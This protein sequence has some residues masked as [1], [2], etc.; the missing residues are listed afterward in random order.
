MGDVP[1]VTLETDVYN[2]ELGHAAKHN[3][4]NAQVNELTEAWNDRTTDPD[5]F[6][7]TAAALAEYGGYE[8]A[9]AGTAITP[10]LLLVGQQ[11]IA[12]S[13]RVLRSSEEERAILTP[14]GRSSKN[15]VN[16]DSTAWTISGV[17]QS[18]DT[19]RTKDGASQSKRFVATGAGAASARLDMTLTFPA[20]SI[21]RAWIWLDDPTL[22]TGLTLDIYQDSGPATPWTRAASQSNATLKKGWN[23]LTWAAS[24]GTH[25]NWGNVY[26]IR[27]TWTSVSSLAAVNVQRVWVESPAK[28]QIMFIADRGYRTF[29][30]DGLPDFRSRGLNLTWALDPLTH[31]MYTGT[32]NEVI[33]DAEVAT[34]Y[35]AGDDISTHA[36]DGAVTST[37]SAARLLWDHLSTLKWLSD[38]GYQRGHLWR[39]AWTQNAAPQHAV[40]QPYAAAYATPTDNGGV[41]CWPPVDRYNI[42]RLALHNRSA[43]TVDGYFATLAKT[44]GLVVFYT[45]GIH[46]DGITNGGA[47][48]TP[49]EWAYFWTKADA[50]LAAGT[51]EF[52]TFSQLLARAGG[53]LRA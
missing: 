34:F 37:M 46:T 45:H 17:T 27:F 22:V 14:D 5:L 44:N 9:D 2:G 6:A 52:V 49:T 25:S 13:A 24:A 29:V 31:G 47:D 35:A 18:D 40:V 8:V 7:S 50:M 21:V 23:L 1:S 15:I 28:A 16:G 43:A 11:A 3:A 53:V 26:R 10:D 39:A 32:K 19:T 42:N 12:A 51:L 41:Q 4:V 38:R 36:F 33:T 48:M 30:D 20:G